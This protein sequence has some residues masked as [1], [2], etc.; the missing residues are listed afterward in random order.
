MS[1]LVL[2]RCA[3]FGMGMASSVGVLVA[4]LVFVLVRCASFGM[5]MGGAVGVLVAGLVR[6]FVAELVYNVTGGQWSACRGLCDIQHKQS[7]IK[8]RDQHNSTGEIRIDSPGPVKFGGIT[9]G[10]GIVVAGFLDVV[11]IRDI[12]HTQATGVIGF[13]QKIATG[14]EVVIDGRI[15]VGER[16]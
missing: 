11:H 12:K 14:F 9:C 1:G 15:A 5:G 8:I 7:G 2:V 16:A 3:S 4:G 10:K 6:M 13:E